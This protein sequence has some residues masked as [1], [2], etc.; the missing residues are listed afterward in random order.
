MTKIIKS[1]L[2]IYKRFEKDI[3]GNYLFRTLNKLKDINP[4]DRTKRILI[5]SFHLKMFSY[6]HYV[7]R[8]YFY[9]YF[10]YFIPKFEYLVLNDKN[11]TLMKKARTEAFFLNY[12]YTHLGFKQLKKILTYPKEIY[13]R[14]ENVFFS[15]LERRIDVLCY[16]L[17]LCYSIWSLKTL[18][19]N[20][21]ILVNQTIVYSPNYKV[22]SNDFV[23]IHPKYR[24][25]VKKIFQRAYKKN[26]FY[27]YI[28][29]YFEFNL[30]TLTFY[31]LNNYF[32]VDKIIYPYTLRRYTAKSRFLLLK[33]IKKL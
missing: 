25:I 28:P 18:L 32:S 17:N 29:L 2:K 7:E 21:F 11:K 12:Y 13:F 14:L 16:R 22:N 8:H 26:F 33:F 15:Y 23:S 24:F 6:I 1:K 19:K 5:N 30:K 20:R 27:R 31:F 9:R 3:W 4:L 10:K